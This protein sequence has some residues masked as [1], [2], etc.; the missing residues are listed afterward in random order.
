MVIALIA[1][2]S[3]CLRMLV[4][5]KTSSALRILQF[6][7]CF[8]KTPATDLGP[9]PMESREL[10]RWPVPVLNAS[11]IKIRPVMCLS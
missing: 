11:M 1:K 4:F 10:R 7:P 6:N 8:S 3:N 5:D 2:W 9:H